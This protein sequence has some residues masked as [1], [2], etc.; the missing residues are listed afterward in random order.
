MTDLNIIFK[1]LDCWEICKVASSILKKDNIFENTVLLKV[2]VK[3][4]ITISIYP[5]FKIT[6][7]ISKLMLYDSGHQILSKKSNV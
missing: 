6:F 4:V 3:K 5:F 1:D 7:A 2:R